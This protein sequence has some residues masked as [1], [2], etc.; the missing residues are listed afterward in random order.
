MC[1][2]RHL[3]FKYVRGMHTKRACQKRCFC[4][5]SHS[6]SAV[7]WQQGEL[8]AAH[9]PDA[10]HLP[11]QDPHGA[12]IRVTHAGAEALQAGC[13]HLCLLHLQQCIPEG[14][15]SGRLF[16]ARQ[17]HNSRQDIPQGGKISQPFK[18]RAAR[19][20]KHGPL[21]PNICHLYTHATSIHMQIRSNMEPPT[22][23][24]ATQPHNCHTTLKAPQAPIVLLK[25]P[26]CS[27]PVRW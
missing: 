20:T 5:S 26:G 19:H 1:V 27:R 10:I 13:K 25:L 21:R 14:R 24:H 17:L 16:A 15:H 11:K 6:C 4:W 22:Q 2:S 18:K 8:L 12:G 9:L 7:R 23:R 3:V